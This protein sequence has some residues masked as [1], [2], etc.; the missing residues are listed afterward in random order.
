MARRTET[1][2]ETVILDGI[3][4][5]RAAVGFEL[6]SE[7]IEEDLYEVEILEE[8]EDRLIRES[9]DGPDEPE[10]SGERIALFLEPAKLPRLEITDHQGVTRYRTVGLA[11]LVTI[12]DRSAILEALKQEAIRTALTPELPPGTLFAGVVEAPSY[13]E[14]IVTGALPPREQ[15]FVWQDRSYLIRMPVLAWR[16]VW[17]EDDRRL[18][19]LRLAVAAPG[20]ETADADT[21]L[22]R[23][24]FANVY[25]GN[26]YSE[27]CWYTM[28][29]VRMD[30]KDVVSLGVHGFLSVEDNGDLFGRGE[31]QNSAHKEYA[32]FLEAVETEGLKD[33]WLIPHQMTLR[34]FHE[35]GGPTR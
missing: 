20:V 3:P 34:E 25:T 11:D 33:E 35:K 22:Y 23:W 13:R 6:D 30:L 1:A 14:I 8:A 16:A 24:P 12:L 5:E 2:V 21:P 28:R 26:H 9:E 17:R 4:A 29:Q 15:P 10:G 32:D 7:D 27:V 31:S 18:S 19:S